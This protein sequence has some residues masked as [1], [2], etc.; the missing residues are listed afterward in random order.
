MLYE[1]L[2]QRASK[3]LKVK[4]IAS[5]PNLQIFQT[6]SFLIYKFTIFQF[7]NESFG[8]ILA[9]ATL[10]LTSGHD[11][12]SWHLFCSKARRMERIT[13]TAVLEIESSKIRIV[14]EGVLQLQA[15]KQ[16][17]QYKKVFVI[18]NTQYEKSSNKSHLKMGSF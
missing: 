1:V 6:L 7:Q 13:Y 14:L 9:T 17:N 12:L 8:G 3:I 11:P 16:Q 2:V 15:N 10:S 5:F 4:R 18:Y